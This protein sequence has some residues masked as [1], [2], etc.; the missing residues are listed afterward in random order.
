MQAGSAGS[1][2]GI[3]PRLAGAGWAASF[4]GFVTALA[5]NILLGLALVYLVK[6]GDMPWKESNYERPTPCLVPNSTLI[7][8]PAAEIFFFMNVTKLYNEDDCKPWEY[9]NEGKFAGE[10]YFASCIVWVICFLAVIKGAKSIQYVSMITVTVPYIFLF[11]LMGKFI[12][13]NSEVD[14]SGIAF[15]MGSEKIKIP[16]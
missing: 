2:R 6:S 13:L 9:P 7:K 4:A 5:Y 8:P 12:S 11:I 10:L 15:Y 1:L 14:G 3:I 16:V